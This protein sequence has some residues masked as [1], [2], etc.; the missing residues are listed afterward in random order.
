MKFS[1]FSSLAL[2]A[3]AVMAMPAV[4]A[5]SALQ[6]RASNTSAPFYLKTSGG[7]NEQHNNLY[8]VA[9]HTGAGFNDAVLESSSQNAAKGV[10]NGTNVQFELGTSFPWGIDMGSDTNYGAWEFVQINA[11]Y[12]TSGFSINS[13]GLEWNTE[14][15]FGGWLVCDW[16]HNAPQLF[17]LVEYYQAELPSSCDKVQ[18]KPEYVS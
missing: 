16:W 10:L 9:Y 3:S 7:A 13:T 12:G 2:L 18:L 15:G 1:I 8:L 11:G 5:N 6:R 4:P 17:Y 14:D